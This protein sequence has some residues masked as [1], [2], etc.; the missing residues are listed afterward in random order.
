MSI[1]VQKAIYAANKGVDVTVAVVK[2]V[3]AGTTT[4]KVM[5]SDL[6]VSDP[7]FGVTKS[8]TVQYTI[9]GDTRFKGGVDGDT[10]TLD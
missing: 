4:I 8:F 6:G 1:Q 5:P 3:D 2:L 7:D 10:I 9:N